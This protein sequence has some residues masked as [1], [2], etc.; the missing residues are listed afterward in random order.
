[1]LR[2]KKKTIEDF[3]KFFTCKTKK[4]VKNITVKWL[5]CSPGPG[6]ESF[7]IFNYSIIIIFGFYFIYIN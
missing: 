5:L 4:I 6:R 2:E 7:P 3:H 1:M